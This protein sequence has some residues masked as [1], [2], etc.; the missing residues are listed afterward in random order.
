MSPSLHIRSLLTDKTDL[1]RTRVVASDEPA[2]AAP[3]EAILRVDR[4]ALTTN[5]ITYAAYGDAMDY[6]RFFPC[7]EPGWGRMPAWGFAD[8]IVS[9]VD[10]IAPGERFYGYLPLATHVRMRPERVTARGFYDGAEHRRS[11]VSAYNQYTRCTADPGWSAHREDLQA[12]VRPLFI[13]SY[14]LA[15]FL[16]DNRYFGASRLVF[17]SASSK[18]AYGT[19]FQLAGGAGPRR[20]A[21]TSPGRMDFV[22]SLGVYD[23]VHGYASLEQ[24]TRDSATV[25]VDFS[26][27][28]A[29][30]RRAHAHLGPALVY[31]CLAGSA[32]NTALPDAADL[33]GP[34]PKLF[35]APVQISKRNAEWGHAQVNGRFGA[36]QSAFIERASDGEAPWM[37]VVRSF[38]LE[39]G[40]DIIDALNA[41]RTDPAQGHVLM[42]AT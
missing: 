27:N 9:A 16:Q 34:A 36:A 31:D 21:L 22:S 40:V 5:N 32:A 41:G 2:Q 19:A 20:V 17:S 10:G 3:G 7:S 15:D 1:G 4:V 24:L 6:W 33:P 23:E 38:G 29:L 8:V 13:T 37:S 28:D 42:V 26:G 30:R 12:L 35:F 25:Y 14:M 11:L 18:T 39:S